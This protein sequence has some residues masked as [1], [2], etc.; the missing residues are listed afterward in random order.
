M[1]D[2]ITRGSVGQIWKMFIDIKTV[3]VNRIEGFFT[4]SLILTESD[5]DIL[6]VLILR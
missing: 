6:L 5:P 4:V 1:Y 3:E 2:L